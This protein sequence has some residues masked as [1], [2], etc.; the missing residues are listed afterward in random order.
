MRESVHPLQI[1]SISAID[2]NIDAFIKSF[3]YN[4]FL[5]KKI[6]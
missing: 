5:Y 6:I 2:L 3:V 4:K 1:L